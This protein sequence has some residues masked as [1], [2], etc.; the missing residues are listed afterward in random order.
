MGEEEDSG[1]SMDQTSLSSL[2][3]NLDALSSSSEEGPLDVKKCQDFAIT[4]VCNSEEAD[5]Q[6]NSDEAISDE[7]FPAVFGARDIRQVVRRHDKPPGGPTRRTDWVVSQQEPSAPAV[8][9]VTGTCKPGNM[10]RTAST[11]PLTL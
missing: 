10:Y 3:F 7:E 1:S 9:L 6:V 8:D 11:S 2:Y 5:T 4:F